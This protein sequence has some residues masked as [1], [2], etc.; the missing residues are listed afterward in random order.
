MKLLEPT[1]HPRLKEAVAVVFL[2]TGL[3]VFFSLASYHP[4]D[5]SL[6]TASDVVKPGNLTGR[7]GAFLADFFL[8]TFGLGAYA[9]P[10]L[11][12]W[13]S[14]KLIWSSIIDSAWAKL[15]GA[16]M[17][18]GASCAA[19]GLFSGWRPIAGVIPAGGLVGSGLA[20]SLIG[21]MNLTGAILATAACWICSL[22]LVSTFEMSRVPGW[23]RGPIAWGRSLY[24]RF[25]AW[26][27]ERARRA[28]LQA[29]ARAL[30]KTLKPEKAKAAAAAAAAQGG[31][32]I[33]DPLAPPEPRS[34]LSK[35][36]SAELDDI[37][38]R[39]LEFNPPTQQ[40]ME[41]VPAPEQPPTP[42]PALSPRRT[43]ESSAPR[44]TEFR[45]P[46][47]DL[48]QEAAARTA[49]DS[50]ELKETAALI[51]S[52]FQ[53]FNVLGS[54][55]QI[56]PGPVVTTFEFKPEA[57][58]KYSRITTLSEDLCLGL[59]AESILIERIPGKP[60]VGIEVPNSKREVISSAPDSGIGG[61]HRVAVAAHGRAGQRH[62]RADQGSRAGCHAAPAHRR[63]HGLRQE[64]D[65]QFS[66]HVHP[67]QGHAAPGP[68]DHGGPQAAGIRA[69]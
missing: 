5:P 10:A 30:R 18:I 20:E 65:A 61:V 27:E 37:P 6:N 58:V 53:E 39:T 48:L 43:R 62:Q 63:I 35:A 29:Q 33:V 42:V 31:V 15:C 12:F 32:P 40:K 44:R 47:T 3:F 16:V 59:Q 34:V 52:K 19:L 1:R 4:F 23:F 25:Q 17:L 68:H 64:R 11:I 26:R 67:V 7:T 50:Q 69:V 56:N 45:Q 46:P 38:I 66:D 57:G 54:V 13:L 41:L 22:Y 60:T 8:Q 14:L 24:A 49:Y 9:I 21:S 2:L 36:L 55:V 28:R 51:K